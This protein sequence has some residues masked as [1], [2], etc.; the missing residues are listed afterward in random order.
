[1]DNHREFGYEDH[2]DIFSADAAELEDTAAHDEGIMDSSHGFGT[3]ERRMH[4]RAYNHW[5]M[6][7]GEKSFPSVDDLDL[8]ILDDF[9]PN[10]VLLDFTS[11]IENPGIAHIGSA[12]AEESG[13]DDD[14]QYV[15]EI[16][17]RSLLSRITDHYMEILA[18]QAPI[19]FEAEFVNQLGKTIMYRGILLPF[20]SDDDT[21]DFVFGVINWKMLADKTSTDELLLEV[22]QALGEQQLFTDAPSVWDNQGE[23]SDQDDELILPDVAFGESAR[24]DEDVEK[25]HTPLSVS[26]DPLNGSISDSVPSQ[27]HSL[28]FSASASSE[29][30]SED[31]VEQDIDAPVE[32]S[33][34]TL[35]QPSEDADL[36][37]WLGLAQMQAEKAAQSESRSRGALYRAIGLAYDVSLVAER[38]PQSL[39]SALEGAGITVQDR[40]PMTPIVKLVFGAEYDKTRLTEYAAALSYA[41]RKSL[42][43]GGLPDF[44]DSHEGGLKGVVREERRLRRPDGEDAS[45]QNTLEE[46]YQ[47]LRQVDAQPIDAIDLADAEFGVLVVRR[48]AD[49]QLV[50]AAV[51]ADSKITD[52]VVRK[53]C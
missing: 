15:S 39:D 11:G 53:I 42:P 35:N 33:E 7:L 37:E 40:A 10:S 2:S 31:Q 34:E 16:P 12:V 27:R 23:H 13:I 28:A 38:E 26:A 24:K 46:A 8:D 1:M 41:H 18:N 25:M 30:L 9:V 43:I 50:V 51:S 21:I 32:D 20:S 14:V 3:D 47:T 36:H 49:G 22:E 29:L 5:V 44:L 17:G 52:M 19:G 4:V 45:V 6:L 48:D